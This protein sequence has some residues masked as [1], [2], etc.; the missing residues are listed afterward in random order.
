MGMR[1]RVRVPRPVHVHV[2]VVPVF[3][4]VSNRKLSLVIQIILKHKFNYINIL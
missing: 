1:L 4:G 3:L 2:P